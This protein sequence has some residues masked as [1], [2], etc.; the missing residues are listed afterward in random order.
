[1]LKIMKCNI[2]KQCLKI[3]HHWE[4]DF[5]GIFIGDSPN[6]AAPVLYDPD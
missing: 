6:H 4:K 1:M 3:L 5:F 2:F